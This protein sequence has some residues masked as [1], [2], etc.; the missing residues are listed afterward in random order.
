M[1]GGKWAAANVGQP[2]LVEACADD[3]CQAGERHGRLISQSEGRWAS[4]ARGNNQSTWCVQSSER[5]STSN[6]QSNRLRTITKCSIPILLIRRMKVHDA[7][8]H[9][10][11]G[12]VREPY[13]RVSGSEGRW[14]E[15]EKNTYSHRWLARP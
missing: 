1:P 6:G 12:E 3:R 14:D 2:V 15:R 13:I 8:L 5:L 7:N 11:A 10:H 9:L 4:S